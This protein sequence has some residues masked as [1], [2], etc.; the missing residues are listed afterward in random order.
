MKIGIIGAGAL[1]LTCA[2]ELSKKGHQVEV[3][4]KENSVGG[5][6]VDFEYEG[7]HLEKFYHHLFRTDT[8]I[9]SL[10]HEIGLGDKLIWKKPNTSVYYRG[11]VYPIDS[12]MA[13]LR[14]TPISLID[15]LR[16]GLVM[17]Y[18]KIQPNFKLFEGITAVYWLKKYLGKASYSVLWEPLLKAKFGDFYDKIAMSW[19]WARVHYRTAQLGYL[20]EGFYQFYEKLKEAFL[21]KGG[22]ITFGVNIDRIGSENTR[23]YVIVGGRKSYFDKLVVCT[24]TPVFFKLCPDIPLEYR[25]KYHLP[26]YFGAQ[27]VVLQTKRKVMDVYWCNINDAAIPF[28]A[29][30]EHTNFMDPKD[31]GDSHL[32]YLGNY[33]SPEDA[34]Y[35]KEPDKVIKEY[36]EGLKK[37]KGDF[38]DSWILKSWVFRTVF[39]QQSVDIDYYKQI[40]P[41]ET[42][43]QNVYLANMAQVYPQDRGQNYSVA[44][45]KK[46]AE[47]IS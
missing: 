12:P 11:V 16:L 45:G 10:I 1:G 15:R 6:A 17:V 30:V 31:Y 8:T 34:R 37:L 29:Y 25:E 4:E 47:A 41:F 18:L 26:Q 19:F 21:S 7:W 32:I 46:I 20:K 39:A 44:L 36:I 38:D 2:Y 14:F 35:N 23:P 33:F 24:P 3:L 40:P 42:S 43:L 5:L 27:V 13:V 22:K 28:M 9:T